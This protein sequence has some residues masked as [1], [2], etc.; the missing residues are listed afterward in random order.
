M[1]T[2]KRRT[3]IKNSAL[4]G[5]TFALS[6]GKLFAFSPNETLRIAIIGCGGRAKAL[7]QSISLC[8][9][10]QISHF[11]EV[12]QAILDD[13]FAY[14][15]DKLNLPYKPKAERDF[16]KILDNKNVDAVAI[17]T[18]DHWHAPMAIMAMQAGKHVYVEKPCSQNPHENE[19]LVKAY[20][21]YNKV[22]Q[23]GNQ[24]RSSISSAVAIADIREGLIGDVHYAKAWYTNA[25][26]PIGKGTETAVPASL[27]WDLWQG[28]APRTAYR[29]NVH[30]YNWHWFRAWGT[31][32]LHNNGTHE[33][34]ICRWA[35]G[36]DHPVRVVSSGGRYHFNDDWEYYDTQNASFEFEGGKSITWEGRSCNNL[37]QYGRGRGV[38]LHGTK[39]S[40]LLDRESYILYDLQGKQI[41]EVKEPDP[42]TSAS[43]S[44]TSGFD[45]LT[46]RHMQNFINSIREG[47]SLNAPID[48]ASISVQLC[49]LGNIAQD[50]QQS[51]TIDPGNGKILNNP[52]AMKQWKRVYEKGWEPQV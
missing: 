31:G 2:I 22:C 47:E 12:D 28:P 23:M 5:A 11:C 16:R 8:Q 42:G 38:T 7:T 51:L 27:D 1:D 4:A 3:F 43:T 48:Q 41:K 50:M 20:K 34:D 13:H 14:A 25:R 39:G 32:E 37:N 33:I 19:L 35:L 46:I 6:S 36:V 40:M 17:A 21:K 10:A 24:Q 26:G 30:P 18:P 45:G 44:D 52:E 9:G 29:D 15:Y 49:H